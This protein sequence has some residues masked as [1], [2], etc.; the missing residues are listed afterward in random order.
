LKQG[1][2]T[3]VW[4]NDKTTFVLFPQVY[5][6]FVTEL[7]KNHQDLVKA[8]TLAQ[9]KLDDYSAIDFLNTLLGTTVKRDTPMEVGYAQLLDAIRMRSTN[10][11]SQ[12]AI[13]RVAKQFKN[14]SLF[15][16]RSDPSKPMFPDE[17]NQ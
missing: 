15:P 3:T 8:M 6:D 4:G 10:T 2:G 17:P 11:A 1:D 9:V 7:Y 14:H 12:A 16:A 13:E 5:T